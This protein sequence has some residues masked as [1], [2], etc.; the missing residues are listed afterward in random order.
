MPQIIDY[1]YNYSTNSAGT[2]ISCDVP[3]TNAGDILLALVTA[4]TGAKTFTS[5]GWTAVTG[6]ALTAA[7]RIYLLWRV[8]T[9]VSEPASYTFTASSG[10]TFNCTIISIRDA[11]TTTPFITPTTTTRAS[12]NTAFPSITT[13]RDNS[14][15]LYYGGHPSTSVI[16]SIIEGNVIQLLQIDGTAHS[17]SIGW[18]IQEK[19]GATG[20]TVISSVTGTTY[21]GPLLTIA[22]RPPSSGATLI[23]AYCSSD[24][25]SLLHSVQLTTFRG[26]SAMASNT[27]NFGTSLAGKT[28]AGATTVARKDIGINTYRPTTGQPSPVN[29]TWSSSTITMSS[30]LTDIANKNILV[31]VRPYLPIDIQTLESVGLGRGIAFGMYST[32]G[33]AY[34]IHHVHGAN[35]T[36]GINYAPLVI[37]TGATKGVIGS[38]GTLDANNIAGFGFFV[39]GFVVAADIAWTMLWAL[40]TTVV[41]GGNSNTPVNIEGIVTAI[42]TGH[43][44]M[45]AIQQGKNQMLCLQ[46]FQLGNGTNNIYLNLFSAAIEFPEQYNINSKQVF[47]CSADNVAGVTF[48][49]SASDYMDLRSSIWSSESKF[50]WRWNSLSSSS[51]T[52]LTEGM[53]VIGAGDVQLCSSVSFTEVVFNNCTTITQNSGIV[54][55]CNITNSLLKSNNLSNI[56]N[57]SFES[58][59]TGHAIEITTPGTYTFNGNTFSGYGITGSTNAAIYNNSGGSVVI[60]ITGGG[61]IPTYRNGTS[62]TTSV[63]SAANVTITGLKINSEVR[64]YLGTDPSTSTE[65]DGIESSGTSF[66]FS[67]SNSGSDGYIVIFN[68]GYLPIKLDITYSGSDSSIPVQQ[69]LDRNYQA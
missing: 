20:T 65:I 30:I 4:D 14:L 21:N 66:T 48:Y 50:H 63:V 44:R 9:G 55:S 7:T 39:S 32:S 42:A 11:D 47:Y 12:H 61:D 29:R 16:P 19:A 68:T 17:D 37:N 27:A 43:E 38:A 33:S 10:E 60:N 31:H 52:V 49:T 15:I 62:A 6:G 51:A 45:S 67:Q 26:T 35:T 64:A 22:I 24:N 57:S 46:P 58:T 54:D 23:P 18:T 40:D 59:T 13:D 53:Q 69:I 28:V 34:K 56:S 41:N 36:W 5:S 8:S 3:S 25:S 2:T 1:S